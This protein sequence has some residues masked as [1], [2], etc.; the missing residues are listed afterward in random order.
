MTCSGSCAASPASRCGA[1]FAAYPAGVHCCCAASANVD[2]AVCGGGWSPCPSPCVSHA[3]LQL[4][5]LRLDLPPEESDHPY[6]DELEHLI[7]SECPS[8]R[9]ELEGELLEYPESATW[10]GF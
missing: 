9:P 8:C 3:L 10:P 2:A 6:T 1:F 5:S 7:R 4:L